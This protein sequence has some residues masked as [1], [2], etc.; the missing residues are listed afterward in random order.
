MGLRGTRASIHS[1][2]V[3]W[4]TTPFR[5][6]GS[7][8]TNS[9]A[10][11]RVVK[12]AMALW[13]AARALKV[14]RGNNPGLQDLIG[15]KLVYGEHVSAER[16][17]AAVAGMESYLRQGD[18]PAD[19]E[20]RA[21]L[22]KL[23]LDALLDEAGTSSRALLRAATLFGMPVPESVIGVL[24]GQ[25]GGSPDRLRGLGLLDPYPDIYDPARIALAA[26]PLAAGRIEPLSPAE[27][28]ALAALTAGPLFAVWGGATP[29]PFRDG[30][31]DVQLARL[32]L[33]ADDP[34]ITAACAP[35]AVASLLDGPA[36]GAFRLGQDAIGL[37]DR[38]GRPVP[39]GL[40]RQTANAAVTSGDG[41]T[42]E[43]LLRRA[44][45][46]A[47]AEGAEGADPLGQARVIA[48]RARH[49]ITRGQP[50]QAEHDL[51]HAHQLFTAGGSEFEAA[52]VMGTIADIAFHR[53]ERARSS[54]RPSSGSA[55]PAPP[56]SPGARSPTSPTG[57]ADGTFTKV[58]D[59]LAEPH[60]VPLSQA[61]ELQALLG[62]RDTV[63]ALLDAETASSEDTPQ[64]SELR[65]D[66]GCRYDS[67][68][69]A[70]GPINRFSQRR[71]GRADPQTGE[72][73]L[74]QIRPAQGGF[75]D[76]PFSP[77]VY[78]LEEFDPAGQRAAKADIFSRRVIAPRAPRLGADTPADALA[79]SLDTCG[80]A[81]L[82]EIARL[83]GTSE[84]DARG[85]LGTLVFDDP[86]SG[87]LI[88]AAEYLSGQVRIKLE[89]ARAAAED[90]PRFA[91][92]AGEL[93][94]VI[95]ADLTP[96]EIDARMGAAW[97]DASYVQQ[98]L[99]E[100]LDDRSIQ[101][102]HPGG[103]VWAVKGARHSVLAT[104]TWGIGAAPRPS[105]PRPSSSS[106]PS[107]ST[108][109]CRPATGNAPSSTRTRPWPPRR[110][111]PRWAS[112]SPNGSGKTPPAPPPSPASTTTGSTASSC[113][114]TT[115]PTR[116]CPAWP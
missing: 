70:F 91:I 104:S 59:G 82:A 68:L 57:G 73:K 92:N 98:F 19:T 71:T 5:T 40:L 45:E 102:E 39:L 99:R 43:A 28:A 33:A 116:P 101:V 17:E 29:R 77:L 47:E 115:T 67:Y 2:T 80:Q 18:L 61:A 65:T 72:E 35:G 106:A 105:W 7:P 74:A 11:S 85:Q 13:L 93:R 95:P 94:K 63:R 48:E 26:G 37:L 30:V 55:T 53:G 100:L 103:Q 78:A 50:A 89:Q 14:C 113:A 83:L 69:D 81:R 41:E 20:V 12:T 87:N 60:P 75:R 1:R 97:I 52:V 32:A 112:G 66:L 51:R 22:E 6:N 10:D 58:I 109:R 111:P 42:G 16:A 108:T 49:L 23:A 15:L 4:R 88:P 27:Q 56:P 84:E 8:L 76:D 90:D 38:H 36:A 107:L 24:A 114:T 3:Q 31:L 96:G 54:C 46:Q 110:K 25:V 64:I 62:L 34:A 9:S 21:F 86:E 44:V 79:I